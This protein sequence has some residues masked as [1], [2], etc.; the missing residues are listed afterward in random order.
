[1]QSSARTTGA[2]RT[3][4]PFRVRLLENTKDLF[5]RMERASAPKDVTPT[6]FHP[7]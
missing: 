2:V 1:M 6:A 3:R 7:L 5:I 4:P